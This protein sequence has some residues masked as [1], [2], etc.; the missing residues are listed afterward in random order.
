MLFLN[1]KEY[2]IGALD[3][4][5]GIFVYNSLEDEEKALSKYSG[6]VDYDLSN[7]KNKLSKVIF[8]F[9]KRNF[10]D[11]IKN[12]KDILNKIQIKDKNCYEILQKLCKLNLDKFKFWLSD[13]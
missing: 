6:M 1:Y 10:L 13:N 3:F 2:K 4:V 8:S 5:D 9:F 11:E 12:R 7:S